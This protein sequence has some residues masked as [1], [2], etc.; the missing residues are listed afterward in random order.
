VIKVIG[1]I[2]VFKERY[3]HVDRPDLAEHIFN[4][5]NQQMYDVILLKKSKAQKTIL[6]TTD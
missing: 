5:F 3:T 6:W 1:T 2:A 4:L